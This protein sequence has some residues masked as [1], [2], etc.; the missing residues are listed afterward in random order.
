MT[1]NNSNR[2]GQGRK[3]AK[4]P[5]QPGARM[6][7]KGRQRAAERF[8]TGGPV[9]RATRPGRGAKVG[10]SKAKPT[11]ETALPYRVVQR[12]RRFVVLLYGSPVKFPFLS[13]FRL[14]QDALTVAHWLNVG[15][16]E[17]RTEAL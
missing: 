17:V 13:S 6:P 14:R 9:S 11:A 1:T 15:C 16:T 5:P 2:A 8:S 7:G 4:V 3:P 12:K 10:R